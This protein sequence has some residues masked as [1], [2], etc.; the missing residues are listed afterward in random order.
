MATQHEAHKLG[1][2]GWVRNREDGGVELVACGSSDAVAQ[3]EIWLRR[4]PPNARVAA[5][6]REVAEDQGFSGFSIR[7]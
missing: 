4:G 3:L 6:V 5:V 2:S 7:Y 1:V